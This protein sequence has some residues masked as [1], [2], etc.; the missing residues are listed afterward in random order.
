[1]EQRVA[2]MSK[3]HPDYPRCTHQAYDQNMWNEQDGILWKKLDINGFVLYNLC[4]G[5]IINLR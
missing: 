1:M 5:V 2:D 3:Y 4:V